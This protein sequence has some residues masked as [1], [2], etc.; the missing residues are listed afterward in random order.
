MRGSSHLRSALMIGAAS[1]IAAPLAV[2]QS[3]GSTH[4]ILS[5]YFWA[6]ATR[7]TA[8]AGGETTPVDMSFGDLTHH[9]N[10]GFMAA[11]EARRERWIMLVDA[12]YAALGEDDDTPG[13]L[14][15]N[16]SIKLHQ[17]MIQPEIGY[18]ALRRPWGGVDALG[19][20]RIWHLSTDLT[21]VPV[22]GASRTDSGDQSWVDGFVGSRIRVEPGNRWHLSVLGDVGAGGSDLTWEAAAGAG[23]DVSQCCALTL[24]YR[25]LD[26]DYESSEFVNDLY[27]T[28]PILGF[29]WRF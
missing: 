3:D 13:P 27:M 7:G 22:A 25:H 20:I 1:V 11:F 26:V 14:L 12:F 29:S 28:G 17:L 4:Y 23:Y 9:L 15:T 2:A 24:G 6:P 18:T 21:F 19:G 16:V 5:P 8:G 10:F